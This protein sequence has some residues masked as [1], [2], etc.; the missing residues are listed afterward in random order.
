MSSTLELVEVRLLGLP[1]PLLRE[2]Q[3]H[4]D[5]LQREFSHVAAAE[6]D[7]APVRLTAL[8]QH[9]RGKYGSFTAPVQAQIDEAA[10]R[11]DDTIDVTF[12]VP[13]GAADA[14]LQMSAMLQEVDEYCREGELLTLAPSDENIKLRNW[15]LNQF[16][17][18]INGAEP[19][20]FDEYQP[21]SR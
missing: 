7:S 15:Y 9:L 13:R 19:V 8:S 1:I 2:A 17:D 11:G 4:S 12:E 20:P 10:A 3:Q 18:Q 16:I 6:S 14:A 21:K 5:E